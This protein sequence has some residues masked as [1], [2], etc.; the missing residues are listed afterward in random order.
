MT[1]MTEQE[2]AFMRNHF[3]YLSEPIEEQPHEIIDGSDLLTRQGLQEKLDEIH[4]FMESQFFLTTASIFSKRYSYYI[5]TGILAMMSAFNKCPDFR[6]QNFRLVRVDEDKKWLPKLNF[7]SIE[8][9]LPE[10]FERKKWLRE[11]LTQLFKEHVRP[12][13]LH[14]N[15]LTRLSM[16]VLWENF[17]I[18]LFWF[19]E[20]F[21]KEHFTGEQLA[22]IYDDFHF[23]V[24]EL[25]GAVFGEEKN[26]FH[27][28]H[29]QPKLPSGARER[30]CCCLSYKL[31]EESGYCKVCPHRC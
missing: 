30:K 4:I 29:Y 6:P 18:Y 22:Q 17:A 3:R 25:D 14:I 20:R 21:A 31:N 7:V 27:Y 19:Y 16:N 5:V 1:H 9:T 26:P 2:E 28:F 10:P 12:L 23:I 8:V 13:F 15:Q 11:N 24:H